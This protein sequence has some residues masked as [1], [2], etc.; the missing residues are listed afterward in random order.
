MLENELKE[1]ERLRVEMNE[2]LNP[3]EADAAKEGD[4]QLAQSVMAETQDDG[5]EVTTAEVSEESSTA[6]EGVVDGDEARPAHE[7]SLGSEP[8]LNSAEEA[9]SA[10]Q[11]TPD[12]DTTDGNLQNSDSASLQDTQ[13]GK[14]SA[15]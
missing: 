1:A 12:Q 8:E 14:Q 5:D 4:K 9:S 2:E 13:T 11:G 7:E 3:A 10:V 6:V 15:A